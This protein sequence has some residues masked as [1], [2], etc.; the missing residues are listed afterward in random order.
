MYTIDMLRVSDKRALKKLFFGKLGIIFLLI[1]FILF[2]KGTWGVYTK[3]S[4]AQKNKERA[5]QELE[6]LYKREMLLKE[7]LAQL[8][9]KR[10]LEEEIR[11]KFDVGREGERLI[12]LVD[13]PSREEVV[14]LS[15]AGIWF[16]I[17]RF[18]G[19]E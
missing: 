5:V 17:V 18:F 8:N 16:R 15:D 13:T 6:T 19:F 7:E 9:T 12:V 14:E 10:G 1:L 11:Q 2:A 4:F 3:A